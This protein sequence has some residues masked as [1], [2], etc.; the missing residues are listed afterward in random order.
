[1]SPAQKCGVGS[2][3]QGRRPCDI[4]EGEL[5]ALQQGARGQRWK[6]LHMK[7]ILKNAIQAARRKMCGCCGKTWADM[8]AAALV[9]D[10]WYQ[11]KVCLD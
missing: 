8:Y 5:H 2:F 11:A 10:P 6:R 1:M 7:R 4:Q 9:L 3:R